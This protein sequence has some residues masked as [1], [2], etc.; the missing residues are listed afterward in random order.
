MGIIGFD[1]GQQD[2]LELHESMAVINV[3]KLPLDRWQLSPAVCGR[4]YSTEL[5]LHQSWRQCRKPL[6]VVAK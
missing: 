2:D 1:F 3:A 5:T 6:P 4:V